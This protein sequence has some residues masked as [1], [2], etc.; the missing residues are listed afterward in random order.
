MRGY[1]PIDYLLHKGRFI[2]YQNIYNFNYIKCSTA[3]ITTVQDG[4]NYYFNSIQKY[5]KYVEN[6]YEFK[7]YLKLIKLLIR[8]CID[9]KVNDLVSN[10]KNS[11]VFYKVCKYLDRV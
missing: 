9:F 3:N 6:T 1:T 11:D 2:V 8:E 5:R 10:V 4:F 7:E